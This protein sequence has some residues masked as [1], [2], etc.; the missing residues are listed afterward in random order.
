MSSQLTYYPAVFRG[1]SEPGSYQHGQVYHIAIVK[2]T[3]YP[4]CVISQE[5]PDQENEFLVIA[6]I[7][8]NWKL[9]PNQ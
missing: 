4:Y 6:T 7:R 2:G 5:F 1:E 3:F 9:P 8:E